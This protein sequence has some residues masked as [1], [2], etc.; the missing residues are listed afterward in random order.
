M[1]KNKVGRK[2]LSL[3]TV[4]KVTGFNSDNLVNILKNKGITLS[5]IKKKDNKTLLISVNSADNEKFFAITEDLCYNIKKVGEKGRLHIVAEIFRN[6]GL[7]IGALVFTVFCAISDDYVFS[8][9]YRGSGS[10]LS[11]EI[12][13]YLKSQNIDRFSR[14]SE[15]DVSSLSDKILAASDKIS[16]AECVK[17]GNRLII[18]LALS[19]DPVKTIDGDKENLVS[20][21]DGEIEYIK[22]YRGTAVKAVGDRV[23]AGETVCGGYAVIKDTE[24]KVGVIATV[25]VKAEYVYTYASENDGEEDIAAVFAEIAFGD[26]EIISSYTEKTSL[27]DGTYEY[28]VKIIY[29]RLLYG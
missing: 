7:L 18:D 22:V 23:S 16:F 25:S 27:A 12:T 3:F 29:R 9:E 24:V 5:D 21:V 1:R 15:I 2:E 17:R 28:K 4:Y 14:F 11:R 20:D 6:L 8:I 10:V 13:A 19:V 26:G